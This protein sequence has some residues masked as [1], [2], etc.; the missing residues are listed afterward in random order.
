MN[1]QYPCEEWAEKLAARHQEDLTPQEHLALQE[2]L[3][4]CPACAAQYEVY[5][6]L[7]AR[8]RELP[9]PE[10]PPSFLPILQK[11]REKAKSLP[12]L[13][14]AG[15]LE[16]P[17]RSSPREGK[18]LALVIGVNAVAS[19]HLSPLYSA[20]RDALD[21]AVVL[22]QN[23]GFELITPPLIGKEATSSNILESLANLAYECRETDEV[24]IYFAG[25][26]YSPGTSSRNHDLL[27]WPY[28]WDESKGITSALSVDQISRWI[29]SKLHARHV[30]LILDACHAGGIPEMK[31]SSPSLWTQERLAGYFARSEHDNALTL[32]ASAT[33]QEFLSSPGGN[34]SLPM[35]LRRALLRRGKRMRD[36]HASGEVTDLQQVYRYLEEAIT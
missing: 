8:I 13:S 29:T 35:L 10:P 33:G 28:D 11:L 27:L 18:R 20:E 32:L 12:V 30:L 7:E 36:N 9:S 19:A 16:E 26:G 15:Q 2:H 34:E 17:E 24:I 3:A 25:H 4:R 14:S 5:Q 31:S 6:S 23:A 1:D 22:R 21:L